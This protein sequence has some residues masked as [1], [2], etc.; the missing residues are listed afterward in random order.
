MIFGEGQPSIYSIRLAILALTIICSST[1]NNHQESWF[2]E[3]DSLYSRD[4][5][6]NKEMLVINMI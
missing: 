5:L 1:R 6:E 3:P 2:M 4:T